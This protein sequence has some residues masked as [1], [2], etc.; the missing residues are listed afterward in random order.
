M[1]TASISF[2]T[3]SSVTCTISGLQYQARN[4]DSFQYTLYYSTVGSSGPWNY[5]SQY[6][7][8]N[9]LSSSYSHSH[10]FTSQI[11]KY[12][13]VDIVATFGG[14][15]NTFI[16]YGTRPNLS[17][18]S[19]TS[20][21][22]D[23]TRAFFI[24]WTNSSGATGYQLAYYNFDTAT[25]SY[26]SGITSSNYF[27]TGLYYDT[28]YQLNVYAYNA[29]NWSNYSNPSFKYTRPKTPNTPSTTNLTSTSVTI[30]TTISS[31][32]FNDTSRSH[33]LFEWRQSGGSWSSQLVSNSSGTASLSL[34]SLNPS[35]NYEARVKSY[36]STS[37][38]YSNDYSST[39]FF[40]TLEGA[41][42]PPGAFT[43]PTIVYDNTN[44]LAAWGA[45]STSGVTYRLEKSYDNGSTWP[46]AYTTSNTSYTINAFSNSQVKLRVRA[47][48]NSLN[49]SW[50]YSSNFTVQFTCDSP[51]SVSVTQPGQTY[52]VDIY[53]QWGANNTGVD[54]R[55]G[56][57]QV[58]WNDYPNQQ[59]DLYPS[60][61]YNFGVGSI[62]NK[63]FQVRGVRFVN[64]TYYYSSWVNATP[65]PINITVTRPS[66]WAWS[67]TISSGSSVYSVSGKNI[68]IMPNTEWNSFTSRINEFRVYKSLSSYSFAS[69]LS[70]GNATTTIINQALDAIRDM[71]AYFTGGNTLPTNRSTGD[72]ILDAS[73]YTDMRDCLNSIA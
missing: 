69:V 8:S 29:Y 45:S 39:H 5:E 12:Y 52:S 36:S 22:N 17:T 40:T 14:T 23:Y 67:Y 1:A 7:D 10:T 15:P 16:G 54:I 58:N 38:L 62:G 33:I 70:G 34:I 44:T 72:E 13:R 9:P 57:D 37:G 61:N 64:S 48:K 3:S 55:W 19:I 56:T 27:L 68:Y 63:Y 28:Y 41:P 53:Y 59:N 2:P 30:Q 46:N 51:T 73:L 65:Y 25:W 4:Y 20:V 21:S 42:N 24:D 60:P 71:S 47:E 49:S 66:N 31:G 18:P 50:V 26:I 6:T 35:T 11:K 43:A 32:S